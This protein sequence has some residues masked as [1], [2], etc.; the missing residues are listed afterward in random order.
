M[1]I[2]T[3][4]RKTLKVAGWAFAAV[5]LVLA[6]F[7]GLLAFPGFLFAHKLQLGNLVAY[8][9]EDLGDSINPVLHEVERRLATSEINDLAITH[10]IFFAHDEQIFG[11]LQNAR[12][13]LLR[14]TIGINPS[15]T[16]NVSWPPHLSHIVTFDV[17][18]PTHDALHRQ[19]W[20]GRFNLTDILTHEV[21]HTLVLAKVGLANISRLPMW[22]AEGYPEYIATAAI[23]TQPGYTLRASVA[24][25]MAA[26]VAALKDATGNFAPMRYDCIGKSYLKNERGDFS[27]TCYYLSRVLVEYLL[28]VKRLTFAQLAESSTDETQTLTELLRDYRSGRL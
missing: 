8:S 6:T 15:P 21:T 10:R 12:A 18:D 9:G 13:E 14:R 22:K 4:V 19:E 23:R 16:Y 25:V 20:P 7:M 28:D 5:F 1:T 2:R 17:P 3:R 27:H 24:R 26:D 11:A